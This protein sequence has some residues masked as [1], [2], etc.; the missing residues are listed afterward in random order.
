[1]DPL[2]T[3][4]IEF[5]EKNME[6]HVRKACETFALIQKLREQQPVPEFTPSIDLSFLNG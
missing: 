1:M 5:L 6:E 4:L 3:Q 2:T